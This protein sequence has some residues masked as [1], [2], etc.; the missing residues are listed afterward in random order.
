MATAAGSV[1]KEKVCTEERA[2]IEAYRKKHDIDGLMQGLVVQIMSERPDSLPAEHFSHLL[3]MDVMKQKAD[4]GRCSMLDMS[5]AAQASEVPGRRLAQLFQASKVIAS[6]IVPKET[7]NL[8]I[9]ETIE[10]LNCDRVSLFI[11]DK[12]IGML[13][14]NAS[15]L[16]QP[17]RVSP[18]QGIAGRCF[19]TQ[20][21]VNIH[22]CYS[23]S[24]FDQT[25]DKMTGY[26]TNSLVCMPI[27]AFD[28]ECLGVLQA[29]NKKDWAHFTHVD[30]ILMEN[31]TQHCGIALRNAEIFRAAIVT[32]ERANA[33]LQLIS[34]LSQ[35]LGLQSVVLTVTTH[36]SD[37]VQADRCTVFLVNESKKQLWSISTDDGKEIVIPKTAGIAGECA[38]EGKLIVIPE[39]YE[40]PRFNQAIDAK[41]GYRTQSILAVPVLSRRSRTAIAVVQMINKMEFDGEV[42]KFDEEDVQLMETFATFVASRLELSSSLLNKQNNSSKESEAGAAFGT[43]HNDHESGKKKTDTH[44]GG[45]AE[46]DEDEDG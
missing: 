41:T 24:Q 35:D 12:R 27:M 31:L 39:A 42:G 29:I 8:I 36:A 33:L 37:L 38:T 26:R 10:L 40:D 34:S 9:T 15:N 19:T 25:F 28:G 45:F 32:S 23:D 5:D 1:D 20:S 46:G 21:L 7:I 14:L 11:F 4:S 30:E 22:D 43:V 3:R 16:E 18:G 44:M 17:I 2:A 6:E 13:V